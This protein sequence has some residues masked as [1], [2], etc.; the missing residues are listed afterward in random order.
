VH[1]DPHIVD[2]IDDVFDLLRIDNVIR[3]MIIHLGIG[4]ET[5]L[6]TLGNE[7]F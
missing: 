6:L 3:Q 1:R 5:L 7:I 4:E 2:H